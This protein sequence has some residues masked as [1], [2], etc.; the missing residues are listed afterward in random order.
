MCVAGRRKH[1]V[2]LSYT[3]QNMFKDDPKVDIFLECNIAHVSTIR[4]FI[5]KFVVGTKLEQRKRRKSR[6][7]GKSR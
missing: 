6:T 4:P 3:I 5:C 1:K 2:H 7:C